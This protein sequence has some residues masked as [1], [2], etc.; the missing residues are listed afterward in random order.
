MSL[1]RLS[2]PILTRAQLV[3]LFAAAVATAAAVLFAHDPAAGGLFPPCPFRAAT[4]LLCPGCGS[5][6]GLH[7][8]LHGELATALRL[9]PLMVVALPVLLVAGLAAAWTRLRRRVA[10]RFRHRAWA[11]GTLAVLLAYW[12]LRN[13]A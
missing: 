8:L 9:N 2:S 6:R 10:G 12:V 13:M 1:A 11:W 4:G 5:L 7:R 3:G